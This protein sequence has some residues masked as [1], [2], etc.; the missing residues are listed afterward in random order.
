MDIVFDGCHDRNIKYLTSIGEFVGEEY[1]KW[2]A[3]VSAIFNLLLQMECRI[4]SNQKSE[5]S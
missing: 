3:C 1:I 4:K 2:Q 5:K